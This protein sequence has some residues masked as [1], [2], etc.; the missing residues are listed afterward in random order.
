MPPS[1][2]SSKTPPGFESR[3]P[4]NRLPRGGRLRPHD[5]RFAARVCE[6]IPVTVLSHARGVRPRARRIRTVNDSSIGLSIRRQVALDD[7]SFATSSMT[8]ATTCTTENWSSW[9]ARLTPGSSPVPPGGFTC[10]RFASRLRSPS[11][12]PGPRSAWSSHCGVSDGRPGSSRRSRELWPRPQRNSSA[13][14]SC[15]KSAKTIPSA[16]QTT[17]ALETTGI[18]E[19]RD[20]V[21]HESHSG[22]IGERSRIGSPDIT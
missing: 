3:N 15:G 11:T 4:G 16:S 22:W 5:I 10:H 9:Q 20:D 14:S 19:G 13:T 12:R 7:Q 18:D 8:T 6:A 17:R 2:L 21:P 1:S